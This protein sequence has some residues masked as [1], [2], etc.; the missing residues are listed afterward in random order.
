MGF[1]KRRRN[2]GSMDN[3]LNDASAMVPRYSS[4]PARNTTE[5][6]EAFGKNPRLAPIDK[7]AGDLS[8][9]TGKLYR[10]DRDGNRSEIARHPL[11][12]L[13]KR[14]NPLVEM[15]ASAMWKLLQE[16]LLLK[17]EAYLLIER[18]PDGMPA[19][20]WPIPVQW[21]QQ[22]PYL[23]FPFY[24]IRTTGGMVMQ[25]PVDDVFLMKDLNPL[26]PYRRGLGQAEAVADEAELDEYAAKFQKQFFYNGAT[27]DTVVIL[28][29]TDDK[30]VIRFR[31]KWNEKFR[32]FMQSHGVAVLSGPKDGMQP[33]VAKLA[34]NM[35][36]MDMVNGRTFT[37]DAI[38]E[39]FGMPREIMGITQNSNRATADAAQY[40]YAKN[41]LWPRLMQRQDAINI[42]LIPCYGDDLVWEY[43]D[44]IPKDEAFYK[45][46]AMEGWGNGLLTRNQALW[47]MK[48]ETNEQGD[49][50]KINFTDMFVYEDEDLVQ[51]SS[52]AAG[53]QYGQDISPLGDGQGQIEIFP[54]E[55]DP[56]DNEIVLHKAREMKNRELQAASW[57]LEVVRQGQG[58]K[59]EAAISKYLRGQAGKIESA[60]RGKQKAE[61][62]IWEQ[63]NMSKEEYEA[64]TPAQREQLAAQFA[65]SLMDWGKEGEVLENLLAPLWKETYSKGAEQTRGLYRLNGIQQPSLVSVARLRGGQRITQITQTTKDTIRQ[66]IVA[67]LEEGKNRQTLTEEIA[68]V[69]NTSDTRARLIAA[70]ECNTSLLAGN[71][72]MAKYGGFQHKTWHITDPLKARDTHRKLNGKTVRIDEPF[73]TALGNKLM[74]PCD[75]DC[76]KAEETVNCHCFLTYS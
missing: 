60:L 38:M 33:T 52:Q 24:T 14:P 39:H 17:G 46:V 25:V 44:I 47:L 7:I 1:F 75:P 21:V 6:M 64:L 53:I 30:Q 19:E 11:L 72:D 5:W 76:N 71:F 29:G 41:V 10:L 70:Q 74:M 8:Y 69:M 23:G 4:P 3:F 58:R 2:V 51:M 50:Y 28:P 31:E 9:A 16:Y 37:R 22:T 15:T 57:S 67:G 43:D 40:I 63:L 68:K 32:G 27:P 36:D 18:Y 62:D 20:L 56:D 55:G 73:I 12:E 54:E 59:F 35:K 26:D 42:Q 49:I 13:L 66:V 61:G 48:Q 34:D 65:D 45:A